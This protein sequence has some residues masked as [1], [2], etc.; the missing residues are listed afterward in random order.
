MGAWGEKNMGFKAL[1]RKGGVMLGLI[2][3]LYM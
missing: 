2:Y 3:I 1:K